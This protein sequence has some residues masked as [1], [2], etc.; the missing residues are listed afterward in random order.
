MAAGED[1]A[2][3]IVLDAFGIP[4]RRRVVDD[5]FDLLGD[6]LDGVEPRA[7]AYAVDGLEA[8]G[9]DEPG[10]RVGRHAITRPLLERRAKR[11]V[12]CLLG[13]VEVAKQTDQ[14]GEDAA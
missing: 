13:E 8:T 12:Q 5:G 7:P 11:I 14:R 4:W 10:S 3:S 9:R 2:Q 1:Q 6:I